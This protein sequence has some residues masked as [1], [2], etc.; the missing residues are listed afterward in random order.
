MDQGTSL[1]EA[2]GTGREVIE[3]L[4][5]NHIYATIAGVGTRLPGGRGNGRRATHDGVLGVNMKRRSDVDLWARHGS[6][7]HEGKR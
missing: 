4:Q 2:S 7:V 1:R 5:S 3:T 6:H